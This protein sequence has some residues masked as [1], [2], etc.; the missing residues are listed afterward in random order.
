VQNWA[1]V[2]MLAVQDQNGDGI[3]QLNEFF[4]RD[5]IV[6]LATP[7]IAGLPYVIS[8]LVAAGG[9]AAAMSTADGLLLAIANALSHDVYYKMVDPHASTKRR[10][11][12]ARILLVIVALGAAWLASTRPADILSMVAWAFS[13]AAAGNFPALVLGI[14]SKRVN[15]TGAV[16]G[17]L[18]GFGVTLFYLVATR[19]L[20]MDLW[21]GVS[22]ISAALFGMP[23]GFIVMYGVS[24]MTPAP[25]Q[26][27]QDLLD[28]IRRPHARTVM[29]GGDLVVR[30]RP[31]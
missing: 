19:Y 24:L 14:W 1:Q 20:G 25:S 31:A 17:I 30:P 13:L 26:E 18:T 28:D 12:V 15:A 4:M 29:Q 27:M 21:F 3:V 5:D 2:G 22:N 10:L 7:E 9:M 11:L 6:V 16:A 8:G 23:V